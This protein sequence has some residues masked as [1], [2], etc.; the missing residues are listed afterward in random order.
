MCGAHVMVDVERQPPRI[1][2]QL[3]PRWKIVPSSHGCVTEVGAG[4][5][6]VIGRSAAGAGVDV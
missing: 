6:A 1:E 2:F 5:G 3:N 4:S